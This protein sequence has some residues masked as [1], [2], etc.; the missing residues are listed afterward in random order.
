MRL[1]QGPS[2]VVLLL[3][4]RFIDYENLTLNTPVRRLANCGLKSFVYHFTLE[5]CGSFSSS[6]E[7]T[8]VIQGNLSFN[9]PRCRYVVHHRLAGP[10][11]EVLA[12]SAT[13]LHLKECSNDCFGNNTA[14]C[15]NLTSLKTPLIC[16][17]GQCT[18]SLYKVAIHLR[19][20]EEE[21]EKQKTVCEKSSI[22]AFK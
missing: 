3:W 1:N 16:L 10:L 22:I 7:H 19:N 9:L 17:H 11:V 2:H 12:V 20:Y 14:L 4:C 13:R 21:K 8:R 5:S 6:I 15:A 18:Q